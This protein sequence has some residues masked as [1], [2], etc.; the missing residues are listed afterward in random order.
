M[1]DTAD[2]SLSEL[3][4]QATTDPAARPA[5]YEAL[6]ESHVY[7]IANTAQAADGLATL[8]AGEDIEIENW[9]KKD[10]SLFIPFFSSAEELRKC[11]ED[12][13]NFL[14][15]PAHD[16]FE[17]TVGA[18][19]VLDPAGD[20]GKEFLP[21]EIQ[22]LLNGQIPG[23]P[24]IYV[25]DKAQEVLLFQPA[26]YPQALADRLAE[27]FGRHDSV[28]A[29]YLSMMINPARSEQ[30]QLVIGLVAGS[31]AAF[32]NASH[33]AGPA[34]EGM[35]EPGAALNFLYMGKTE[36]AAKKEGGLTASLVQN[37]PFYKKQKGFSLFGGR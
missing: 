33:E 36:N 22:A 2:T 19:L 25:S 28:T 37:K 1:T 21:G 26:V 15:L 6:L 20:Y 29:A 9:Q 11:T 24:E 4:A 12:D 13:A 5:F 35:L 32:E 16:L 27:L 10:G 23:N 3:L 30:P 31:E 7:I 8:N 34:A 18:V 17:I 14:Q